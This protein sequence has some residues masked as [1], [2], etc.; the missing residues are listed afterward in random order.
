MKWRPM[1]SAPT[2]GSSILLKTPSGIVSACYCPGEWDY[3]GYEDTPELE[4]DIWSCYDDN[5]QIEVECTPYGNQCVATA[6]MPI[7]TENKRVTVIKSKLISAYRWCKNEFS[8]K[9]VTIP[10]TGLVGLAALE[11]IK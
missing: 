6:W 8:V 9:P 10:V 2:D 7:P 11:V 1:I 3:G 5:F 4:N